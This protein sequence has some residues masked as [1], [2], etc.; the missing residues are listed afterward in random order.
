MSAA[1]RAASSRPTSSR[2]M[3]LRPSAIAW[4]QF[5]QHHQF[6]QR[7]RADHLPDPWPAADRLDC[8]RRIVERQAFV[9][10]GVMLVRADIFVARPPDHDRAGD[11]FVQ[12]APATAAEAA[13]ADI[14]ERMVAVRFGVGLVGRTRVAAVVEH[15][16]AAIVQ[17]RSRRHTP[18]ITAAIGEGNAPVR[19]R[20]RWSSEALGEGDRPT[21]FHA[22]D[23]AMLYWV[24]AND[25]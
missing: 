15:P 3:S 21:A 11:Q 14:G 9:A 10:A 19:R 6:G 13:L 23:L 4:R 2:P 22:R 12:P 25:G 5:A 18:R 20:R 16:H 24:D 1:K 7:R 17:I 8:R